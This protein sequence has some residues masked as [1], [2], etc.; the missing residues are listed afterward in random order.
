M[1]PEDR[2]RLARDRVI[3][4]LGTN[5]VLPGTTVPQLA[6][7]YKNLI[8]VIKNYFP[9]ST[10]FCSAILPRPK[11][12]WLTKFFVNSA[13]EL[14]CIIAAKFGCVF[15]PSHKLFLDAGHPRDLFAGDQLHLKGS[16]LFELSELVKQQLAIRSVIGPLQCTQQ[17]AQKLVKKLA[18]R[19]YPQLP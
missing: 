2:Q 19:G 10:I 18:K 11:D 5:N 8:G 3:V 15:L 13:N 16:G 6:S 17:K 4:H 7:Q 14:I 1:D 9:Q 12:F